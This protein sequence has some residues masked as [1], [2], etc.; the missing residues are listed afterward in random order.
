[1]EEKSSYIYGLVD[2]RDFRVRYVGRTASGLPKRLGQHLA[3]TKLRRQTPLTAWLCELIALDNKP[4][5][6]LLTTVADALWREEE[7]R[8]IAAM[9]E[10]GHDLLNTHPGGTGTDG[11]YRWSD[12][13]IERMR[14]AKAGRWCGGV[15]LF[16]GVSRHKKTGKFRAQLCRV[17]LGLF[18][19]EDDAFSAY[20]VAFKNRFCIGVPGWEDWKPNDLLAEIAN[21]TP[22]PKI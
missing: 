20:T 19:C 10:T 2:P 1:M 18:D 13:S 17:H 7:A 15:S 21:R 12:D 4:Y 5:I 6:N 8:V 9:R 11:G 22:H 16:P 3:P 14:Q